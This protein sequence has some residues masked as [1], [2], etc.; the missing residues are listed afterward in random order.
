MRAA[1]A[2]G[3][4]AAGPPAA[5]PAAPELVGSA[6]RPTR[7]TSR[8]RRA[9][10]RACSSSSRAGSVQ[11]LVNGRAAP[12]PFL[13]A[14][15][16][17]RDAAAS[18]GCSR[19]PSRPTTR[20]AACSTSSTPR[21]RRRPRD[22]A[23]AL[24]GLADPDRG[25]IQRVVFTVGSTH[26]ADNHNGGQLA[27]GPDGLLYV[28]TGDG[29]DAKRSRGRRAEP[30]R[31]LGKILRIDPR[32]TGAPTVGARACATRGGSRSTAR[33]ATCDRRRRRR[34]QRGGRLRARRRAGPTSAGRLRGHAGA[35]REPRRRGRAL[36]LPHARGYT[37]RD[38]R[39]RRARPG[40]PT[41]A[42]RYL[43]GDLQ[44]D[45]AVRRR[46]APR[47]TSRGE[48]ACRSP[49][50]PR[51]ARTPAAGIYV[52]ALDGPASTGSPDGCPIAAPRLRLRPPHRRAERRAGAAT[53]TTLQA[54]APQVRPTRQA[55][56][57]ALT[58]GAR[59]SE[60]RR[61]GAREAPP[62]TSAAPCP[63]SRRAG[64]GT[65]RPSGSARSS[66]RRRGWAR[67]RT[68]GVTLLATVASPPTVAR[69][70]RARPLLVA[71]SPS[72]PPTSGTCLAVGQSSSRGALRS[73]RRISSRACSTSSRAL[74][75]AGRLRVFSSPARPT[76]ASKALTAKD[77]VATLLVAPPSFSESFR[78]SSLSRACGPFL[79]ALQ[80]RTSLAPAR[81]V[82]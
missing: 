5:A 77:G 35:L 26:Q 18:E 12:T 7:S 67:R 32:A 76:R 68:V 60:H 1:L 22:R 51:S 8:R 20:R 47:A 21:R 66:V 73:S 52:A 49:A 17:V 53:A 9:T 54:T 41:L 63:R 80:T 55:R 81:G 78:A 72:G 33:P 70:A 23:R 36:N 82:P 31:R 38:R 46:S 61:R 79:D 25:A 3:A 56:P 39:L 10:R 62:A 34:R 43:F 58:H 44:A 28:S 69:S 2:A 27:F 37:R 11:V 29:G 64:A 15:R 19:S 24:G 59:R 14:H 75:A 50:R 71:G 4:A 30:E 40:L 6:L 45:G 74:S 13:D 16:G 42:G 48:T 65:T 57:E